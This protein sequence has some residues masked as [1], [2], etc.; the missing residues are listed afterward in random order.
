[1]GSL[2]RERWYAVIKAH[3]YDHLNQFDQLQVK[4]MGN[5]ES[6]QP[7]ANCSNSVVACTDSFFFF[8][9]KDI[10]KSLV[11]LELADKCVFK[12]K[13]I[14][15]GIQHFSTFAIANESTEYC[16]RCKTY[17]YIYIKCFGKNI[18]LFPLN[19]KK[20]VI[21]QKSK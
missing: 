17:I 7:N 20:I 4:T 5:S 9:L 13:L 3:H 2:T 6:S 11:M 18:H 12:S 10:A 1:M 8:L 19:T 15:S 14:R 21:E 16:Q